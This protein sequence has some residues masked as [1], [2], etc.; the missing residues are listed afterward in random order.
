MQVPLVDLG[1]Q[2]REVATDVAIGF[3]RVLDK[4][5]FILGEDV[6]DHARHGHPGNALR[7]LLH[8]GRLLGFP[9]QGGGGQVQ[10]LRRFFPINLGTSERHVPEQGG[11][12]VLNA[13]VGQG[14][15]RHLDVA[16]HAAHVSGAI[17][18]ATCSLHRVNG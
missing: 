1:W 12:T 11:G 18:I 14:D 17:P 8:R 5:A 15:E 4:T 10:L 7:A 16:I 9:R 2:H 6:G 3:E 13:H